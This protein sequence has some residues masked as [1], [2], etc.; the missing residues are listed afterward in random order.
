MIEMMLATFIYPLL[1]QPLLLYYQRLV[2]ASHKPAFTLG[3]EYPLGGPVYDVPENAS[4]LASVSGPAKAALFSICGV[5]DGLSNKPLLRLLFTALLHP[6][7]PD[8][9]GV[10]TLRTSLE[11]STATPHGRSAIRLDANNSTMNDVRST[12]DFGATPGNRRQSKLH[13]QFSA[14]RD[15]DVEACVFVLSPAL[16]EVLEF[17][18]DDISLIARTRPN[19]YRRAILEILEGPPSISSIRSLAVVAINAAAKRLDACLLSDIAF[20]RD[21]KALSGDAPLDEF[22][23]DS[24]SAHKEDDRGIGGSASHA[25]RTTLERQKAGTAGLDL[26]AE[27]VRAL[28]K[29]C[30]VGEHK[31]QS[32]GEWVFEYDHVATHNLLCFLR[33]NARAIGFAS[34]AVESIW[35]QSSRYIAEVFGKIHPPMGGSSIPLDGCPS[36]NDP[37]FDRFVE[38]VVANYVIFEGMDSRD[39]SPAVNELLRL[40]FQGSDYSIGISCE[41]SFDDLCYRIGQ[42][43]LGG[44]EVDNQ[45]D[46]TDKDEVELAR[47]SV[48]SILKVDALLSLLKEMAESGGRALEDVAPAGLVLSKGGRISV[49]MK[50]CHESNLDKQVFAPLSSHLAQDLFPAT[51]AALAQTGSSMELSGKPLLPC[52]CEAPASLASLFSGDGLGVVSEGVTWQSLYLVF[53]DGTLVVAQP[54]P[55]DDGRVITSCNLERLSVQ[56][57]TVMPDDGPPARRLIMFH[58]GVEPEPPTLFRFDAEPQHEKLGP[59]SRVQGCVSTLDVWFEDQSAAD[60]A[61]QILANQILASKSQRGWMMKE[62]F[63]SGWNLAAN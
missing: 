45:G 38:G 41:G 61:Y 24:I 8:T 2:S 47:Q 30:V 10:P 7:S 6:L 20:G 57:D 16:A 54:L 9:T 34:T 43:L 12:Y 33:G 17:S 51:A 44:L 39:K 42:R 48:V 40:S 27:V 19:P 55:D 35:R 58:S 28:C 4:S 32:V 14:A 18:G 21:L 59:L 62:R 25:S 13:S 5:F 26:T 49:S 23:L 50:D 1:L 63:S 15:G 52:V 46:L 36:I 53:T 37:G 56:L 31:R 29:C 60:H 3:V 11:V 22:T